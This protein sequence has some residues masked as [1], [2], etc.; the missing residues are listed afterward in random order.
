MGSFVV[1]QS[2]ENWLPVVS[3]PRSFRTQLGQFVPNQ[4]FPTHT[5][6]VRFPRQVCLK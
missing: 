3:H 2:Y 6:K 4:S 1:F 5:K